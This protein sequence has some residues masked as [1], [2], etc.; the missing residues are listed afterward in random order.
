MIIKI[1]RPGG[2]WWMEDNL[3]RVSFDNYDSECVYYN[4]SQNDFLI[5]ELNENVKDKKTYSPFDPDVSILDFTNT[6]GKDIL[7]CAWISTRLKNGEKRFIVF[8]TRGYLCN[9][10]GDTLEIIP[11][12]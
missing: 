8:N 1:Q 6:K 10:N 12:H 9:D 11:G 7:F 2:A 4:L 5:C 3:A